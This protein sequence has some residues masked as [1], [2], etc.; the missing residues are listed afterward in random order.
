L[1]SSG[2]LRALETGDSEGLRLFPR[3][4]ELQSVKALVD[5][6]VL[7]LHLWIC[8][9]LRSEVSHSPVLSWLYV[10]DAAHTGVYRV[11]DHH[12]GIRSQQLDDSTEASGYAPQFLGGKHCAMPPLRKLPDLL[13]DDLREPLQYHIKQIKE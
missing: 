11:T 10:V 13:V 2:T 4:S 9:L 8:I 7:W 1:R 3:D 5:P 6:S 12:H